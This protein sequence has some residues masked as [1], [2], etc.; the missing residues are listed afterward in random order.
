MGYY[1]L[2]ELDGRIKENKVEELKKEIKK[3]EKLPD[4]KKPD[5]YH[6]FLVDMKIEKAENN[7]F[8]RI[9]WDDY[10]QKWYDDAKFVKFVAPFLTA[11]DIIFKGEDGETWGY[12]ITEDG[13]I[14]ILEAVL[15][16]RGELTWD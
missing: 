14:I 10:Y 6:Y 3:I 16:E 12:R 5:F 2:M 7:V 4:E 15:I 8:Y 1:S 11:Q 13:K 9:K